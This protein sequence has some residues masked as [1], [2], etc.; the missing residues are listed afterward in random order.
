LLG[1][2]NAE[3][4]KEDIFKPTIGN[5]SLHEMSD[6]N[7]LRVLNFATSKNLTVK[8]T[9]LACHNI[10]KSSWTFPDGKS[11]SQIGHILTGESIQVYLMSDHSEKQSVILTTIC[12]WKIQGENSN[13]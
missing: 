7:G 10:H 6:D 9:M 11:H 8:R 2:F 5:K 3:V 12:W 1:D 13:E 4:G